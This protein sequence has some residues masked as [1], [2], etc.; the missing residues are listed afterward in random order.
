MNIQ[1]L[2]DL[3]GRTALVT[4]SS[5]GIGKAIAVILAAAGAKIFLHASKSGEKLDAAAK[6]INAAGG[7]AIAIAANL[8]SGGEIDTLIQ[9]IGQLDILVLNASTQ[10]YGT[11]ES[12]N[13]DDFQFQYD[14]NVRSTFKLIKAFL[15]GMQERNW[16]RLLS[17]GSVNE[18]KPAPRLAVYSSTKAA[19]TNLILNCARQYSQFGITANNLAPGV[20]MT[21]RNGKALEDGQ[22]REILLESIP[23]KRFGRP[24]DCAAMALL[25][26]SN[27]GAYITGANIPVTG[28]MDL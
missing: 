24:E 16:G 5:R 28:G 12:F 19:Q 2:F 20:I 1:Q 4:G 11:I 6:E 10:F 22:F 26:C 14:V 9:Q 27:A 25:L 13:A 18:F 17:I 23:A 7:E 8:S 21:D 15:P 3:S